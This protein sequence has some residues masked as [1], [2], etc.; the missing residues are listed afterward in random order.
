MSEQIYREEKIN[1]IEH[2]EAD[3]PR[4]EHG[5]VPHDHILWFCS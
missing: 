2:H 4:S 1:V 3:P 5:R